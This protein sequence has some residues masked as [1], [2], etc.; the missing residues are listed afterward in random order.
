VIRLSAYFDAR[1]DSTS[2]ASGFHVHELCFAK[3]KQWHLASI[4]FVE[5]HC[6]NL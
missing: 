2:T 5:R 4:Q 1:S 3:I 6:P